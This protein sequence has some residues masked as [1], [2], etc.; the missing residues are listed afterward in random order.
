[1]ALRDRMPG[2]DKDP[3]AKL[4][5]SARHKLDELKVKLHHQLVEK[6]DFEKLEKIDKG[7]AELEV[8]RIVENLL[9]REGTPLNRFERLQLVR[10]ISHEVFGFGPLE[11]LLHDDAVNDILVNGSHQ[12]FVER[13]GKLVLS[14]VK[15][16]NEDH[17]RQIIDRIVGRVGRRIDES[18]PMVDA[19]LPDGSRVNAIIPPLALNGSSLSIRKFREMPFHADDLVRFGS[20]TK[21]VAD[22]LKLAVGGRFNLIISGGT[23]TGKTT[24]LNILSSHISDA[25]RI[26]TIEDAAELQLQQRHVVRLETRPPN[27]EGKGGVDQRALVKNALRMRP[28]RIIIGEVRGAEALDMLQAMNT[29]HE[30]SI[31]TVHANTPRDAIGRLET[32]AL[33]SETNLTHDSIMRQIAS[34]IHII[35]QLKRFSDGVR[36]L[37][38]LSEVIGLKGDV[39]QIQDI[40]SFNQTGV[41]DKG[42]VVG[43]F[44]KHP[45]QPEF[46]RQLRV[47][48]LIPKSMNLKEWGFKD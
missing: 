47:R 4:S 37:L 48:G 2:G 36:R 41:T 3:A 34:A 10:E 26:I 23:G 46:L 14:D 12:V 28:D 35:L 25:E 18:S 21:E 8:Q 11:T 38:C 9:D 6:I 15:F 27:V 45:C 31:T 30:G 40:V 22:V 29:G 42:E 20:W 32:M 16:R 44:I 7:R 24:M 5:E 43:E 33:Y 13:Q 39:V 19:R 1:M 17:L